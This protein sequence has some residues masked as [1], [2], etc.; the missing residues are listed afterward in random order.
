MRIAIELPK[1]ERVFLV[2]NTLSGEFYWDNGGDRE[3][4]NNDFAET[5]IDEMGKFIS[6]VRHFSQERE[7][8]LKNKDLF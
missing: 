6:T 1:N 5:F 7:V 4:L 3:S 2:Y 8:E